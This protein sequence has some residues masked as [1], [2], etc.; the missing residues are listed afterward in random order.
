MGGVRQPLAESPPCPHAMPAVNW[1]P[2]DFG[3]ARR[4]QWQGER[5]RY[6]AYVCN[7]E[8]AVIAAL[9]DDNDGALGWL[10]KDLLQ[11]AG[12]RGCRRQSGLP[13]APPIAPPRARLTH[14]RP[15]IE[16]R[17]GQVVHVRAWRHLRPRGPA[18][19][20][21]KPPSLRV[22]RRTPWPRA[23]HHATP[24]PPPR[25]RAGP[26]WPPPRAELSSPSTCDMA[27]F[28][29]ARR[30]HRSDPVNPMATVI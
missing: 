1:P 13:P 7:D 6:R 29:R 28:S 19:L 20:R 23:C 15:L 2:E 4:T 10:V 9:E 5:N 12:H 17:P 14:A 24:W 18:I 22:R 8:A 11:A 25:A 3:P 16:L 21:S 27:M 26:R 30:P